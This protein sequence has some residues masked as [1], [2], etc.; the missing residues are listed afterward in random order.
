MPLTRYGVCFGL[1]LSNVLLLTGCTARDFVRTRGQQFVLNGRPFY[2]QGTNYQHLAVPDQRTEQELY[3]DLKAIRDAGHK[4][5]RFWGFSCKGAPHIGEDSIVLDLQGETIQYSEHA[6]QRLDM[7]L[8]AARV[9]DLKV[10]LVLSNF[11]DGFGGIQWW[12]EKSIGSRDKHLFFTNATLRKLYK[13]YAKMRLE[14]VNTRYQHTLKRRIQYKNDPTIM[15]IELMNEPHTDDHYEAMHGQEVPGTMVYQWL[16]EMSEYVASI[17]SRHLISAGDEGY[18]YQPTA[19]TP[20]ARHTWIND[21]SKGVD[22][23]RNLS[24]P[25]IAFATTHWYP[26]NWQIPPADIQNGWVAEHLSRAR[27]RIAHQAGK[28]IILEETGFN[29]IGAWGEYEQLSTEQLAQL[30]TL[31]FEGANQAG[32]AG[33]MVW[34]NFPNPDTTHGGY[35]FDVGHHR[36]SPRPPGTTPDRSPAAGDSVYAISRGSKACHL[37]ALLYP[38]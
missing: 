20:D 13:S 37:K 27:A 6:L 10:I 29:T 26:D 38:C 14:R 24:L 3:A 9:A 35:E 33:T 31:I 4:V 8:D 12:T 25:H 22:F 5:I 36:P 23:E 2:F 34:Q 19:V 30:M 11:W 17:D 28:P 7:V 1:I 32:Y 16:K 15:A 18:T 21:G